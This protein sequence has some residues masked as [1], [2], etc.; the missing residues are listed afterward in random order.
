MRRSPIAMST[1]GMAPV[2]T[3]QALLGCEISPRLTVQLGLSVEKTAEV[4]CQMAGDGC[5]R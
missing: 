4:A 5:G 2:K 1:C 3:R